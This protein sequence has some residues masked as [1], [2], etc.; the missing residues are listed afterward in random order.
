MKNRWMA[1]H[2]AFPC[3]QICT[4]YR[5][6][7]LSLLGIPINSPFTTFV[8]SPESLALRV[9]WEPTEDQ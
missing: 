9:S 5:L 8:V 4:L 7:D 6:I 1:Y 3:E 2:L